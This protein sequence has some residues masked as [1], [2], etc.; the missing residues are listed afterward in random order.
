MSKISGSQI[1]E[2]K[3]NSASYTWDYY[4]HIISSTESDSD[5]AKRIRISDGSVGSVGK[6]EAYYYSR[7]YWQG[8][9]YYYYY[10]NV[11]YPV[12]SL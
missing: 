6:N 1:E 2:T 8:D 3:S 7:S 12:S 9:Y 4:S 10:H 11:V 5:N